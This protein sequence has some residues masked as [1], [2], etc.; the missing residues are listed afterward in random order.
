MDPFRRIEPFKSEEY[1][2]FGIDEQPVKLDALVK[3]TKEETNLWKQI[4]ALHSQNKKRYTL[5][6]CRATVSIVGFSGLVVLMATIAA[7]LLFSNG[8]VWYGLAVLLSSIFI[9]V[10]GRFQSAKRGFYLDMDELLWSKTAKNYLRNSKAARAK[11]KAEIAKL[12][13][14]LA[15]WNK[16]PEAAR[17]DVCLLVALIHDH[18]ANVRLFNAEAKRAKFYVER[19]HLEREKA[20]AGLQAMRE[21]IESQ[22]REIVET[23]MSADAA[24]IALVCQPDGERSL[25]S[26]N[27]EALRAKLNGLGESVR[28]HLALETIIGREL[29]NPEADF[30]RRLLAAKNTSA[31]K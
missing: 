10:A 2:L 20:E 11:N 4:H 13:N 8:K 1:T 7:I 24:C 27:L 16:L 30:E 14:E 31:N 17:N 22:R 5:E 12:K 3:I 6:I 9:S 26:P 29:N 25:I 19:Q 23:I 15:V 21:T 18:N 28:E